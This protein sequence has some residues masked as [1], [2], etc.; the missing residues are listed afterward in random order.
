MKELS[1]SQMLYKK[2]EKHLSLSVYKS[3][4]FIHK[5]SFFQR[6]IAIYLRRRA[7]IDLFSETDFFVVVVVV[8]WG[9]N[10]VDI[11]TKRRS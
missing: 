8:L 3:I 9:D 1:P 5:V 6:K 10:L 7:S 4:Y 11:S 2:F